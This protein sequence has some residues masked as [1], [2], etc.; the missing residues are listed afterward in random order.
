[1]CPTHP[2]VAQTCS[3]GSGHLLNTRIRREQPGYSDTVRRADT[4][5]RRRP[6]VPKTEANAIAAASPANASGQV[7]TA[8]S[9][10]PGGP[11][12]RKPWAVVP[13]GSSDRDLAFLG[14]WIETGFSSR[15][16]WWVTVTAYAAVTGTGISAAAWPARKI[17]RACARAGACLRWRDVA[18]SHAARRS[19]VEHAA[20]QD[21]VTNMSGTAGTN[22]RIGCTNK[23]AAPR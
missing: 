22:S 9:K 18:G 11:V 21:G 20:N 4:R 6:K 19:N 13:P 2:C 7:Q 15:G 8:L 12:P 14:A 1:M 16:P 10:L 17:I 5:R 23:G 3:A